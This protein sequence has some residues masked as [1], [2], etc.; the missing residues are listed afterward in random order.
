MKFTM[1]DVYTRI[2]D[3]TG[4][5][6]DAE[7]E[8]AIEQLERESMP[9][10]DADFIKKGDIVATKGGEGK[11]FIAVLVDERL[12]LATLNPNSGKK[13]DLK[14]INSYNAH[15]DQNRVYLSDLKEKLTSFKDCVII[16]KDRVASITVNVK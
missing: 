6:L 3:N 15:L 8:L 16:D 5:D 2:E 7:M 14:A 13:H 9:F 4:I 11:M 1:N 10:S 12:I